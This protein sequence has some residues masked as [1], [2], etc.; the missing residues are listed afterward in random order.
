MSWSISS[1]FQR[2]STSQPKIGKESLKT[3]I[4]G[5][6]GRSRLSM[7]VPLESS[8][9]VLVMISSK[10]VSICNRFHSRW[11]NSGK[12]TISKGGTPLLC[13]RSRGISW[14]SGTKLP[15]KKLE[16]L[17]YHMVKTWSLYLTWPWIRTGSWRTDRIPVANTRSQ[18]Y[19]LVQLSHVKNVINCASLIPTMVC[20]LVAVVGLMHRWPGR[21]L[22]WRRGAN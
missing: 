4:L 14:H 18:Q 19:L 15:N 2:K 9:A 10:S 7:L 1:I 17:G 21:F 16:T 20:H 12:I 13:P 22:I 3:H 5:V 11:A 6:Q 8:S